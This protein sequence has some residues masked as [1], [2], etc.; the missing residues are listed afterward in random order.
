M[1]DSP[2][3][4]AGQ[5][6]AIDLGTANTLVFVRNRGIVL[7][8]PS[9]VAINTQTNQALAVGMEAKRMIGR[10]PS[11]IRAIR[12][13]RDGVIADFDITEKMLRYFIQK[14]AP[15]SMGQAA[16]RHLCSLWH[17]GGRAASGRRSR[18]SRRSKAC[19]HDRGADGGCD[20]CWNASS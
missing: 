19:L 14:G 16:H 1:A 11:H 5:D 10:T 7:N 12:P 13:L 9:V 20:W 17:Y 18:I 6:M 8:E 15:A 3:S 4:F 2:L